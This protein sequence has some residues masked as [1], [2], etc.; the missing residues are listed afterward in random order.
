MT[1]SELAVKRLLKIQWFKN[2]GHKTSLCNV[3]QVVNKNDFIDK[4]SSIEW[5]NTTLE[6]RNK[7]TGYL[8]K[9]YT[10][11][12]QEWNVTATAASNI[13][14]NE[15]VPIMER[16]IF[17]DSIVLDSLKWDLMAFLMENS[18]RKY[19]K[20]ELFFDC[21]ISVYESGHFPC[22]WEGKW[23]QGQLIIY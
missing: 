16:E 1:I 4:I 23:P 19:L 5:E 10:R 7:I 18:C 6:A 15:I 21:L 2:I 14:D 13:I 17:R 9:R 20:G 11:E 3:R 8:S 22:G 12:F